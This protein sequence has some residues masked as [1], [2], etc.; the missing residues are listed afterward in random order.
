[1][2]SGK[3]GAALGALAVTVL[4]LI[5]CQSPPAP[6]PRAMTVGDILLRA[7][8]VPPG[9]YRCPQ[10]GS[11]AS[12]ARVAA[13]GSL[14]AGAWTR[15]VSDGADQGGIVAFSDGAISCAEELGVATTGRSVTAVV[16]RFR[17]QGGALTAYNRGLLGF[18]SPTQAQDS[19][20]LT[21]GAA[22]GLG[23]HSWVYDPSSGTRLNWIGLWRKGRFLVLL[24]TAGLDEPTSNGLAAIL[25]GRIH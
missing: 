22:T 14:E 20:F 13:P 8:D 3:F 4:A 1:M 23:E 18:D 15:L 11:M 6:P 24:V 16:V 21:V 10:S 7:A 2:A 25:D 12:A 5:A 19:P 9:L 17:T